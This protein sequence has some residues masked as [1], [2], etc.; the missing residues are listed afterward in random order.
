MEEIIVYTILGLAITYVVF[1]LYRR[2]RPKKR[3]CDSKC[4]NCPLVNKCECEK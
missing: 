4:E 2:I 1:R 3:S